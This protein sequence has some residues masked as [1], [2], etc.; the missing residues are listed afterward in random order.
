MTLVGRQ[1]GR[2]RILEELG[3]GGMSVVYKGI[4]TALEREVAVK[5]LHPHLSG[6]EDSR[7]RLAQEA[8]AVAKLHHPNILEVFDFSAV[9]AQES[10][11]VTEYIRGQTLRA[12][13]E[14]EPL[15]QPPELAALVTHELAA[16]LAHAHEAG[17][18]H[19]DLKPENVMV[20]HDGLLKLMDFGIAKIVDRDERMTMTGALVGSPAH[21]APEIIEGEQAGPEADIFSLGT[22][23]F[24]FA[25]GRLPFVAPTTHALLRKILDGT[26]DDPRTLCPA[27]SDELAEIITRCLARNPAERYPDAAGLRD[28]LLDYLTSLGLERT[29]EELESF[30]SAPQSYRTQLTS[31]LVERLIVRAGGFRAEK[32]PSR[33]LSCLNQVLALQADHPQ[34]LALLDEMSAARRRQ[35]SAA[36]LRRTLFAGGALLA[37]V[38][39]GAGVYRNLP[40]APAPVVPAPLVTT[41]A[42]DPAS[43]PDVVPSSPLTLEPLSDP[44]PSAP[45]PVERPVVA[46]VARPKLF[47]VTL[48]VRPYGYIRIDGGARSKQLQQHVVKLPPGKHAIDVSCDLGC[49]EVT[50]EVEVTPGGENLFR[51]RVQL[52]AST[53]AFQYDPPD[54]LIRVGNQTRTAQET[55]E[56]PFEIRSPRGPNMMRHQVSYEVTRPGFQPRREVI[57]IA[58]GAPIRLEGRLQ[59]Q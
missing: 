38:A 27:V 53:L 32:R 37:L 22:M 35:Q 17:V 5:V 47:P 8:K 52:Q 43:V 18:I 39:A 49:D 36:R 48:Q 59:P 21:M 56:R 15:Q 28:A 31:R 3:S 30:F 46:A 54:A 10:Y 20:R 25:T 44:A 6:K 26:F 55:L 11:I 41:A 1:V 19:R 16:A 13:L 29:G 2:Y 12:F 45:P 7:K 14:K 24:L 33:A 57:T 23:L 34:A 42:I 50:E 58:A 9:E 4:D 51:L 40:A